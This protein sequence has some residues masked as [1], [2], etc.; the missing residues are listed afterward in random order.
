MH[1]RSQA[2]A[3]NPGCCQTDSMS[4][5]PSSDSR[6]GPGEIATDS[7]TRRCLCQ[8]EFCS[9]NARC[10][11][12]Q[13]TIHMVQSRAVTAAQQCETHEMAK[14]LMRRVHVQRLIGPVVQH[15]SSRQCL[16][17]SERGCVSGLQTLKTIK[18]F[19]IRPWWAI[20]T[21]RREIGDGPR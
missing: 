1:R 4:T 3:P 13:S 16:R 6:A 18:M 20:H 17:G 14:K 19:R 9:D 2:D 8:S 12:G 7:T 21:L 15:G 11:L 10:G 5:L